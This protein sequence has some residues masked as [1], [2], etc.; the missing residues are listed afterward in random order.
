MP[1]TLNYKI[2]YIH[3][4][5]S[6]FD[7][8]FLEHLTKRFQVCLLTF[9]KG[10][11]MCPQGVEVKRLWDPPYPNSLPVI[12][13]L[14][15]WV[16]VFLR[17]LILS[18]NIKRIEPGV[19]N[20]HWLTTYA[21]YSAIIK[22]FNRRLPLVVTVWGSDV[23]LYPKNSISYRLMA[24]LS[25]KMA[26]AV[27]SDSFAQKKAAVQLGCSPKKIHMFPWGINLG[28]FNARASGME[29][30]QR[31]NWMSN[32]IVISVRNHEPLYNVESL[33]HAIPFVIKSETKARFIVGGGGSLS[34][35]L[36]RLVKELGVEEYV[37]FTGKIPY[38][39]VPKYLAA[40]DIYV[41]TSLS[42]G[43]SASL[44]EAM[45]CGLP[46]IVTDLPANREWVIHG[47]NGYLFSPRQSI[48]LSD[49]ILLLLNNPDLRVTFSKRNVEIAKVKADWRKNSSIFDRVID[50]A[51]KNNS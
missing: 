27:I 18:L 51:S 30:R 14:F 22:L 49:Y 31:L 40:A 45:A 5:N 25:L 35:R 47:E 6:V 26:D 38:K 12:N 48:I 15:F 17:V 50:K 32:L 39:D 42:D 7:H 37:Y 13:F 20:A 10:R 44:M 19:V 9:Y 41:S 43:S 33:I 3:E 23:L 29:V 36:Q 24:K 28:M 11:L 46:V 2:C 8:R 34:G 4:G 16:W 1:N 21:F